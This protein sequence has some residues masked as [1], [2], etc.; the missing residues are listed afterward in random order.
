M[1]DITRNQWFAAGVVIVLLG[2]Q[3]RMVES[4][5]LTPDATRIL[6]RQTGHPVASLNDTI[7]SLTGRTQPM[8]RATLRPP[9]WLGWSLISL[10]SVLILHAMAMKKP[11]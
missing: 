9:E 1:L 11:D 6:A 3:F 7:E 4:Y 5:E 8:P 2:V 10:G